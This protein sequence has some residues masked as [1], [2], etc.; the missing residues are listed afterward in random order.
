MSFLSSRVC[1]RIY[2][3]PVFITFRSSYRLANWQ[4]VT[5][6]ASNFFSFNDILPK[7]YILSN[8]ESVAILIKFPHYFSLTGICLGCKVIYAHPLVRKQFSTKKSYPPNP[9]TIT[10]KKHISIKTYYFETFYQY[11]YWFYKRVYL[12]HCKT[13]WFS[14]Q[15]FYPVF[16]KKQGK[17][18]PQAV[19]K[20]IHSIPQPRNKT[21][22]KY[23]RT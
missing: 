6:P 11:L 23:S 21:A 4:N 3:V 5:A 16:Y 20:L 19:D 14:D 15:Y 10:V 7:N 1:L 2:I 22:G 17:K 13:H 12:Y 18:Y 9:V 8:K